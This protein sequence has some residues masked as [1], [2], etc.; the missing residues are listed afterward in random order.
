MTQLPANL[1]IV[2]V[3]PRDGLQNEPAI[4]PTEDKVEFI[5]RAEAAGARRIEVASLVNPRKVPQMA[6]AEAVLAAL[7]PSRATRIGL[8]LNRRGAERALATK[9]DQLG[10]V[11]VMSDAFGIA[12]QGQ[13]SA[14]TMTSAKEI[15]SM[16]RSAGRTAQITIAIA[17]GCP[18]SGEVDPSN[19]VAAAREAAS[20]GACEIAVADTIGCA[21]PRQVEALT[22]ALVAAIAPLP[23]RVHFHE[24]RGTGIANVWAAIKAGAQTVDASIGGLGGCP[25]APGS[26]GNVATQDVAW[27]LSRPSSN[28]DR[29]L[30]VT[31]LPGSM[32]GN[33]QGRMRRQANMAAEVRRSLNPPARGKPPASLKSL[34]DAA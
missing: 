32:S 31:P 20:S 5:R 18:F 24:T 27:M 19:V 9:V 11:C 28:T 4:L 15:V 33:R 22:T 1:E 30:C 21:T 23:L 29:G 10:A 16:A 2:E 12:N 14:Q 8:V 3:G 25:F 26:S 7:S 13:T 17:F 6:D 34:A